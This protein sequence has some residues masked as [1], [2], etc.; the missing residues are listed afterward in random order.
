MAEKLSAA[1]ARNVAKRAADCTFASLADRFDDDVGVRVPVAGP[2]GF[3]MAHVERLV[4]AERDGLD[5]VGRDAL[6]L[7]GTSRHGLQRGGRRAR[8]CSRGCR[9]RRRGPGLQRASSGTASA[10][11]PGREGATV[12]VVQIVL[13]VVEI[14]AIR[15]LGGEVGFRASGRAGAGPAWSAAGGGDGGAARAEASR[16]QFRSAEA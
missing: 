12:G 11:R 7:A 14:D 16:P 3:V 9:A 13:V 10:R 15:G 2:G 6:R 4:L 8:C 1:R 5:A